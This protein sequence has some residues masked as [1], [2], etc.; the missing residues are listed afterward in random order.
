M[1]PGE[2]STHG[3]NFDEPFG[4]TSAIRATMQENDR[5]KAEKVKEVDIVI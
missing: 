4:E 3:G 1:A 5:K 2:T